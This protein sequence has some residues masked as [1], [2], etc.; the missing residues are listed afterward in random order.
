MQ[1]RSGFVLGARAHYGAAEADRERE[2]KMNSTTE[3]FSASLFHT[4]ALI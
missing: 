4:I 3:H 2:R 1:D